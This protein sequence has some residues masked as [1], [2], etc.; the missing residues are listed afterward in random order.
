MRARRFIRGGI[1]HRSIFY[2]YL[3]LRPLLEAYWL[4]RLGIDPQ[5]ASELRDSVTPLVR[6]RNEDVWIETILRT[7]CKVFPHVVVIENGSDDLTPGILK[8]LVAEGLP[9]AV[10]SYA[11]PFGN[12]GLVRNIVLDNLVRTRWWY[13]VDGDELQ[14]EASCRAVLDACAGDQH[15]DRYFMSAHARYLH[16]D[17]VLKVTRPFAPEVAHKFGRVYNT[18]LVRFPEPGW[19]DTPLVGPLNRY[20]SGRLLPENAVWL[21]DAH[22]LHAA[23]S[24][25]STIAAWKGYGSIHSRHIHRRDRNYRTEESA[26]EPLSVF[27][28]EFLECRYSGHNP[29]RTQILDATNLSF[30]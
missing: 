18:G 13:I 4:R 5:P 11:D 23:F 10:V 27:P 12:D 1:L 25:R 14:L 9:L 22:Y 29:Y 19:R 6:V 21:P 28:K 2:P 15:N 7:L 20:I 17:C 3:A 8:E 24:Q 26:Y 30:V 16:P